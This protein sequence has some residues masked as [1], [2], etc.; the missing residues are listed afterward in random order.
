MKISSLWTAKIVNLLN[1]LAY[2]NFQ[3]YS[4]RFVFVVYVKTVL[5][6]CDS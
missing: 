5:T 4:I 1:L 3:D 6:Y 2:Y